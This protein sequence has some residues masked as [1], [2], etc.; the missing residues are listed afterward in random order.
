L[1]DL[2]VSLVGLQAYLMDLEVGLMGLMGLMGLI[3]GL[4]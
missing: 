4:D 1:I 2:Q 3:D